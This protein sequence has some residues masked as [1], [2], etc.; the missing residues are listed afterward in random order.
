LPPPRLRD[1]GVDC[2]QADRCHGRHW[3]CISNQWSDYVWHFT[4]TQ[5]G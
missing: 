4:C 3:Q 1:P 5:S 2:H